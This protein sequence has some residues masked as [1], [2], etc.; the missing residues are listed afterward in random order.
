MHRRL[1]C[2]SSDITASG[3]HDEWVCFAV[4]VLD[5]KSAKKDDRRRD[6]ALSETQLLA[7][8]CDDCLNKFR[9]VFNDKMF[10]APF[11]KKMEKYVK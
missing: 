6:H 8:P 4:C 3:D 5:V 10:D 2:F 9:R 1:F 7:K 11:A